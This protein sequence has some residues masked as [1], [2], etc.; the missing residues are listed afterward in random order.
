ML[1]GGGGRGGLKGGGGGFGWDPPSSQGPPMVPTEGGPKFFESLNPL[2][3][4]GAEAKLWL[5]ASNIG[6]G[7][8]GEEG[9]LGGGGAPPSYYGV[10]PF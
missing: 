5:S 1:K 6:R 3:A 8:G 10:L 7:G 2:N 4:E 9:G